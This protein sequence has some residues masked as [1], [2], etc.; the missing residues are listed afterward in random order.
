MPDK[1]RDIEVQAKDRWLRVVD[2]ATGDRIGLIDACC[3]VLPG[4]VKWDHSEG[5]LNINFTRRD[6]P[7]MPKSGF[8]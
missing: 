2:K 8:L 4:S 1:W 5:L 7:Q 3:A 6:T